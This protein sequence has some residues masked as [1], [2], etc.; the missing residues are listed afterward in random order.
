[1]NGTFLFTAA[2][3]FAT[4]R[5][6][7]LDMSRTKESFN[8]IYERELSA[9]SVVNTVVDTINMYRR[10]EM[11][12][13]ARITVEAQLLVSRYP[14]DER[15]DALRAEISTLNSLRDQELIQMG[16][17]KEQTNAGH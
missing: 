13:V 6:M 3:V 10:L 2:K 8:T 1:M 15:M 11:R 4:L 16:L 12:A 17:F 14:N 7:G 5:R 9:H